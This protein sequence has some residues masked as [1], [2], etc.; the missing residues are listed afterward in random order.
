MSS[1][2]TFAVE[3]AKTLDLD[4]SFGI[5]CDRVIGIWVRFKFGWNENF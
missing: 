4:W 3:L 1:G 2:S 5:T